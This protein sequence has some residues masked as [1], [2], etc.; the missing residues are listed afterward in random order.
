MWKSGFLYQAEKPHLLVDRPVQKSK[1]KKEF[2][3][4]LKRWK[5]EGK[6]TRE[7]FEHIYLLCQAEWDEESK[8]EII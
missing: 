8:D 6:V 3:K 2:L 1:E 7:E 4:R 5:E